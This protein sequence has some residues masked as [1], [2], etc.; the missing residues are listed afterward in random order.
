[1]HPVRDGRDLAD[2]LDADR[3][4]F[5]LEHPVLPGRPMNV[6]WVALWRGAP[7]SIDDILDP[8]APVADPATVDTAV[9]YSIWNADPGLAGLGR[10]RSL[11]EGAVD[12]LR[13]ELPRVSVFVTLSPVPG[14]RAW[15]EAGGAGDV[16]VEDQRSLLRAGAT[17]LT[18]LRADGRPL[19]AVA[20]FHVGNGARVWR[21]NA[22]ADRS[23]RGGAR[24]FG[25]MVNYR[26]EPEDRAANRAQL[27]SGTVPVSPGVAALLR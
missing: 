5:V 8:E 22:D 23:A 16:D 9:F 13:A 2:R 27:A 15:V 24:S 21:V 7:G 17:Y 25:V 19:D 1:M 6:V 11:I 26:Y 10:G 20:R 14:L 12:L 4:L 18:S 3:R